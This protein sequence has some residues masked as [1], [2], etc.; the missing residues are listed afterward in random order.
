MCTVYDEIDTRAIEVLT[1]IM[2][3]NKDL[4]WSRQLGPMRWGQ[5][6]STG[7]ANVFCT[8]AIQT[9][10]RGDMHDHTKKGCKRARTL[11]IITA[12]PS[13]RVSDMYGAAHMYIGSVNVVILSI[14]GLLE[15][16]RS[17]PKSRYM[18]ALDPRC[19]ASMLN[20]ITVVTNRNPEHFLSL[21]HLPVI[22]TGYPGIVGLPVGT[23]VRTP[24]TLRVVQRGI[25]EI[26]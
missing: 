14:I 12:E 23:V 10:L 8:D 25:T 9:L 2:H 24:H 4:H 18:K 7:K 1:N 21:A 19:V 5:C 26:L 22:N 16:Y 20:R 15:Q 17:R 13:S 6:I 11:Y 3:T